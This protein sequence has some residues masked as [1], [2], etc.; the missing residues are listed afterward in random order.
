[1]LKRFF[2]SML[3]TMAGLWISIALLVVGGII[4]GIAALS[5]SV[6]S[7]PIIPVEKH[8]VLY[9]DLSGS[10]PERFQPASF[11][12]MIQDIENDAP[13]LDEMTRAL[14]SAANDDKIEGLY[15]HSSGSAM[16][17]ASREELLQAIA[18][19][20]ESGKWI[21]AYA[22]SYSQGDYLIAS[23]ADS[24]YLNPMG[25]I[26]LHGI[27]SMTPF[28]KGLLDKLN[29]KVQI[30]KVG[31]FKSA[32]EP[33]ILTSMSEPAR[34][35]M[36]QYCD[37]IWNFVADNIADNRNIKA[38]SIRTMASQAIAF[39]SGDFFLETGLADKLEYR[40]NIDNRLRELTDIKKDDDI[41]LVTPSDYLASME[42]KDKSGKDHVAVLYAVGDIVDSG[43]EGIVGSEMVDEIIELA[44]DDNV[45]GMV[46][47][48]NSPGGSA[49]ASEQIWEALTYFKSQ[50]KPL[51]VSMGDYAAS[52]GYYISCAADT[53]YADVTTLTGS[54]GVF[55]MIPDLSGL[56][57][58]KLGVTFTTVETN[59]NAVGL[60]IVEP[61]NPTIYSSLQKSVETIY[62]TFTKRV[63]DGRGM[64]QDSVKAIAEGRVWS[65]TKALQI[66]LV[67]RIGTLQ[68]AVLDLTYNLGLD[69]DATV[70]YPESEED[71]WMEIIRSSKGFKG[72][73]LRH[74]LPFDKETMRNLMIIK[75]L[76][77]ANPI[78]ARMPDV[79]IY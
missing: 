11:M 65:G 27:G 20:K 1:M 33:F 61:M 25:A 62:D 44:D 64:S 78:Q 5:K 43:D 45:K 2:I 24:L 51:Y 38:D 4:V 71:F 73:N 42:K 14:R 52:G 8:S 49:F 6:T 10:I 31:T 41:R 39:R 58:D 22:D 29:V 7:Q 28:F 37:T 77:E 66:G 57:T 16:G 79:T 21:Y 32:V 63:A 34:L 30:V 69:S 23:T 12:D 35:Q 68:D 40:R 18:E 54:I 70:S 74:E 59:P 47:R 15:I 13:S 19:F 17:Y 3:G 48:V 26:D 55:G 76:K 36:Q 50:G 75:R 72:M 53:I 67:D 56:V 9:I 60:S 46:F